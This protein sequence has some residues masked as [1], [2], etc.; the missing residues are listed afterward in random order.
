M[1]GNAALIR[2]QYC[3]HVDSKAVE[4]VLA[5]TDVYEGAFVNLL[6]VTHL[7]DA[8]DIPQPDP[9]ES[10]TS[11]DDNEERGNQKERPTYVGADDPKPSTFPPLEGCTDWD[12]GWAKFEI[13]DLLPDLL[14]TLRNPDRWEMKYVRPPGLWGSD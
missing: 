13:E 11:E 8:V 1:G 4:S 9:K 6:Q 10:Y 2:Y 14:V 12:V 3:I 5:A 7:P